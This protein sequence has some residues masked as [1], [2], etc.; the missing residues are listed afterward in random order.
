MTA[1]VFDKFKFDLTPIK[2][3]FSIVAIYFACMT[4]VA[5]AVPRL[6]SFEPSFESL[7][8]SDLKSCPVPYSAEYCKSG[9]VGKCE[10]ESFWPQVFNKY[11]WQNTSSR[12]ICPYS[13]SS[14]NQN[15]E[16]WALALWRGRVAPPVPCHVL[17]LGLNY[18]MIVSVMGAR[19]FGFDNRVS[20][21]T[22]FETSLLKQWGFSF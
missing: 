12:P 19:T 1:L 6:P 9:T 5:S 14:K 2:V 22:K 11:S 17:W 10:S 15:S 4:S 21:S 16:S 8:A 7:L 3:L 18:S 20:A 13:N